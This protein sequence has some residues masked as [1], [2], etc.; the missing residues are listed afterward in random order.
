MMS[1]KWQFALLA[2]C[3]AA[4]GLAVA[5]V[6]PDR[7]PKVATLPT[8]YAGS[9]V[10]VHESNPHNGMI[11]QTLIVDAG[12]S[13]RNLRGSIQSSLLG[14]FAESHTRNELYENETVFSRGT[15]GK[16]TDLVVVYDKSSLQP[17]GEIVLPGSKRALLLPRKAMFTLTGD[18][19][20]GLVY[21]FTPA[22]SVT[23]VDLVKRAAVAEIQIP[24][25]S[26]IY[27]MAD[28]SFVTLC[29][30]GALDAIEL[31]S[32]GSAAHE[33]LS[34]PFNDIDNDP[35]FMDS[36][37]I[38]G[39]RYFVSFHGQVQ[40]IALKEQAAQILPRWPLLTAADAK[41]S[42]RPSGFQPMTSDAAG[43]LYVL[44]RKNAR[45]GEQSAGGGEVWVYDVATKQRIARIALKKPGTVA[46]AT[47]GEKPLLTVVNTDQEVDVYDAS[48]GVWIRRIGGWRNITP[49]SM[50]AAWQ[51]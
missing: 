37:S 11:G 38:K 41:E 19:R 25:C 42:W 43:R 48:N 20:F 33:S 46:E 26:M 21:N 13:S 35:L 2:S 45:D 30:G 17:V 3:A 5:D 39:L 22:A 16:R 51:P 1:K 28:H 36:A 47:R 23:V 27:P 29:A 7:G 18:D 8:P 50:Y 14:N 31:D 4:F 10:F 34:A 9:W 24:G 44:M 15:Y 40:P 12:S 32:K 49:F 6:L